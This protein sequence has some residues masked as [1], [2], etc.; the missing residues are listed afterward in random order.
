MLRSIAVIFVILGCH[1]ARAHPDDALKY[2]RSHE[3]KFV[4]DIKSLV[5]IPSVSAN[6]KNLE[7]V[8]RA[9]EWLQN[10]L[11][12]AG[13]ENVQRL[14]T[15]GPRPVVYADWLH[16]GPTKPTVLIYGHYDVQPAEPFDLWTSP[17]FA[18]AIRGDAVYG[19][20]CSDDKGNLLLPIQAAEAILG[21]DNNLP[22]NL[23]FLL[24][25]EEE[26]GSPHLETFL[27]T[28]AALLSAHF[29]LSADGGQPSASYGGISL[30]L[31]GA[32]AMQ[33]EVQSLN[34]DVHS[35]SFGGSVQNAGR[36]LVQ[37]LSTL[38]TTNENGTRVAVEGFYDTVK[39]PSPEDRDDVLARN[40]DDVMEIVTPLEAVDTHGEPG[41][42]TLERLW[43]RPTLEITGYS[44]GFSG[45]G[46]KTII[47]G[48]AVAKLAARLV[49]DQDPAEIAQL[50]EAHT[51]KFHPPGCH[52]TIKELGFKAFPYT[53][54]REGAANGAAAR[55]L[56]QVFDGTQPM[57][58][59]D[60]ATIPA[61]SLFK[62]VLGLETTVFGFG[63]RE[64]LIH[65]PDEHFSLA[66]AEL[67][68]RGW[69]KLMY[70]LGKEGAS[71]AQ[72]DQDTIEKVE[73]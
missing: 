28:H 55:V 20:G 6:P 54:S 42:T 22:I 10:R 25:G 8:L 12:S 59:R 41:F 60:G 68:R 7:D 35:G 46:I 34:R 66:F 71:Q 63:L 52:V 29:V 16:A 19:R 73:L 65:A 11:Q 21:T 44:S 4:E 31:R 51:E 33:V 23:K 72:N 40:F 26:I 32:L 62:S 17:P 43:F 1:L 39:E 36:A 64:D 37:L 61:L 49:P 2:L 30:G 57:Y 27:R 18:P 50:I 38:H 15:E 47:P 14:P 45:D 58:L 48:R 5:S 3:T 67:G 53:M 13:F 24:E 70:E 56:A 9:A 69:L